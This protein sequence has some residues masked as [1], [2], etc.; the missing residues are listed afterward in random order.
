MGSDRTKDVNPTRPVIRN[1]THFM[2]KAWIEEVPGIDVG[3]VALKQ[4]RPTDKR[5]RNL[6][7]CL[8]HA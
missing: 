5:S 4:Y 7:N 3:P 8:E 1:S 2:L 6:L